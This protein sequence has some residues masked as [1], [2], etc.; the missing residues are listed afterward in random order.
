MP[1]C[2]GR[3]TLA[4]PFVTLP[5]IAD[6]NFVLY[7]EDFTLSSRISHA[8]REM[9]KPLNIVGRSAHWDFIVELVNARLGV[10][11]LP[12][13]VVERLDRSNTT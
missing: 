10:T 5:E 13:S 12:R 6:Q 4:W 2:A 11:L 3:L 8:F 9:G 7:P 1:D